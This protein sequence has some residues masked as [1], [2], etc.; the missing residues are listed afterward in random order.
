MHVQMNIYGKDIF[1][2][3]NTG[4]WK[5]I[6]NIQT[7]DYVIGENGSSYKV[8]SIQKHQGLVY[9]VKFNNDY[10]FIPE[11]QKITLLCVK[12]NTLYKKNQKVSISI[13]ELV[14]YKKEVL[15]CLNIVKSGIS[16]FDTI[17]KG[18]PQNI[19]FFGK[20]LV[21]KDDTV[22]L[23]SLE[24][25]KRG[26]LKEIQEKYNL[27]NN[28]K[29]IP[30]C[31]LRSSLEQRFSLIRGI[32]KYSKNIIS[33]ITINE[34]KYF[35]IKVLFDNHNLCKSIYKIISSVGYNCLYKKT[36]LVIYNSSKQCLKQL[37][38]YK[39]NTLPKQNS[40]L[41]FS[42]E[43]D[44]VDIYYSIHVPYIPENTGILI[45]EYILLL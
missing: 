38:K 35:S 10:F 7:T 8:D 15:D 40:V 42:I 41:S 2:V 44:K 6:Q 36:H 9:K 22:F 3:T 27:T 29:T 31:L 25:K 18:F 19:A 1:I 14:N 4:I 32:L 37:Y 16:H 24:K 45:N 20:W 17:E 43:K 28:Y 34:T 23:K 13:H 11:S 33:T 39:H 5:K 26:F 30:H 12:D 21:A